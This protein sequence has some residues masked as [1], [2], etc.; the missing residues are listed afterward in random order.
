MSTWETELRTRRDGA[1]IQSSW[2]VSGLHRAF[3]DGLFCCR[4][5]SARYTIVAEGTC[6][7]LQIQSSTKMHC[8]VKIPPIIALTVSV[9]HLVDLMVCCGL[10][11]WACHVRVM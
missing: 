4:S 2:R 7:Y 9:S 5:Q 1:G 8:L 11:S 10:F 6:L 3:G